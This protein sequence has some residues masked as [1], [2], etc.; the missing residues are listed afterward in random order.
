MDEINQTANRFV[1]QI[2]SSVKKFKQNLK[3]SYLK[4]RDYNIDP[5]ERMIGIMMIRNEN[6]ILEENL[7]NLI[8]I[9]DR[10]FV[11]DGT[12]PED[13]FYRCKAILKK[14]EEV[15]LIIRDKDTDGPFPIKDGAR[16]YLL[17]HVR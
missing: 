14:F 17:N 12:E 16:Y 7:K 3:I 8:N 5:S 11:L 6:D 10:I 15:K 1:M 13:E 2:L 4:W 9:Y